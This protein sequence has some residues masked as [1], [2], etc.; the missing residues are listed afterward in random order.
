MDI[1]PIPTSVGGNNYILFSMD[2]KSDYIIGIPIQSKSTSHL[3]SAVDDIY[4]TRTY[5]FSLHHRRTQSQRNQE[6]AKNP[7]HRSV[8]DS[9]RTTRKESRKKYP[10]GE[11][12]IGIH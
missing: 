11:E 1:I 7:E 9:S 3:I 12:A 8:N 6:N 10:N 5:H 4:S 2:E